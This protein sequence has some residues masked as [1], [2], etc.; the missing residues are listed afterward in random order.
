MVLLA[1][2]VFEARDQSQPSQSLA[3]AARRVLEIAQRVAENATP[4]SAASST[5][6]TTVGKSLPLFP[7][8][9]SAMPNHLARSSLFAPLKP[10]RRKMHDKAQLA[11]RDDVEILFSGKQFDMADNDVLLQAFRVAQCFPTGHDVIF[12]RAAFLRE[13]G[14]CTGK[15]DYT[16]LEESMDRLATGT[17]FIKTKHYKAVLHLVDAYGR[18]DTTGEYWLRIDPEVLKLFSRREYGFID[19]EARRRIGRGQDLAKWLQNYV[20][21]H[22]AGKPHTVAAHFLK[23][24]SGTEGRLRDFHARGLPRALAELRRLGVIQNDRIREDGRV[25][26][27]KPS[28]S[29]RISG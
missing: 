21:S 29:T 10:G 25:T 28:R 12:K 19:L 6:T 26:W 2:P 15:N 27:F 17:L 16:W 22:E 20:G 11:S 4:Q 23:E 1:T 7:E 13:I 9:E 18:S 8:L 5:T 3:P 24:W 14:R